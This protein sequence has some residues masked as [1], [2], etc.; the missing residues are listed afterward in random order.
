[1]IERDMKVIKKSSATY[2]HARTEALLAALAAT[3]EV[4]QVRLNA[5]TLQIMENVTASNPALSTNRLGRIM[6]LEVIFAIGNL[7]DRIG[8]GDHERG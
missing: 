5:L 7:A 4:D 2:A 6:Q 1:M 8:E 3:S